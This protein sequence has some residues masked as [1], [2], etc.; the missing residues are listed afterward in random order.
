MT[1]STP[2][3]AADRRHGGPGA[4]HQRPNLPEG[5]EKREHAA[6]AADDRPAPSPERPAAGPHAKPELTNPDSTPGSGMLPDP[7]DP[8][9]SQ[10]STGG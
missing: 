5:E 8:E 4:S 1:R 10:D 6:D 9:A 2:S 7:D 3:S